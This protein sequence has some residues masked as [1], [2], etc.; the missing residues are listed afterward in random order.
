LLDAAQ[1]DLK[2][3]ER[4]WRGVVLLQGIKLRGEKTEAAPKASKFLQDIQND[5]KKL[6]LIEEQGG[7][8]DLL[9]MSAQAKA[10]ERSGNPARA[11]RSWR[12]L[13]KQYPDS[14]EGKQAAV[15]IARLQKELAERAFLGVACEKGDTTVTDVVPNGPASKA[16]IKADD[17]LLA[18]DQM[19]LTN[20]QD[21]L[22]SIAK[23]K[24]GDKIV[25]EI[26]RGGKLIQI[27]VELGKVP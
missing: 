19:K 20:L 24:A 9:W 22:T 1:A 27:T 18:I 5:D 10:F 25:I 23:H 26:D 2:I 14:K 7:P 8:E 13:A 16:G 21:L 17:K 4:T 12:E 3:P 15:E 11:I 6:K